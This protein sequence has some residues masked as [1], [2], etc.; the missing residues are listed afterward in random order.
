V[1]NL[2]SRGFFV[3]DDAH[4]NYV[5]TPASLPSMLNMQYLDATAQDQD[6]TGIRRDLAD[7]GQDNAVRATFESMGYE[8]INVGASFW[9]FTRHNPHAD[10]NLDCGRMDEFAMVLVGTTMVQAAQDWLLPHEFRDRVHCGFER[11]S[12]VAEMPEPTYAFVHFISPHAPYVFD[13]EGNGVNPGQY[14]VSSTSGAKAYV[15][16]LRYINTQVE[17][18]VDDLLSAP[19]PEPIIIIHSDHGQPSGEASRRF[20]F[21]ANALDDALEAEEKSPEFLEF[22]HQRAGVL[23][24]LYLPGEPAVEPVDDISL[25]NE[26]RFVFDAYYGADMGML[27]DRVYAS[28]YERPFDWQDVTQWVE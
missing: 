6:T 8:T 28:A 16:Q 5:Q 4:S 25:V 13:A 21:Q 27:E 12:Q 10:V 15:E 9:G 1:E 14:D 17:A 7:F 19:G 22:L 2:R 18:L 24:A 23:N 20:L 11:L 26:F 3:A